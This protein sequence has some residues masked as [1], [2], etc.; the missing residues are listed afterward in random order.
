MTYEWIFMDEWRCE[1]ATLK[2]IVIKLTQKA[3][4]SKT[5]VNKICII[6]LNAML[7]WISLIG[8]LS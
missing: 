2:L 8:Q 6:I 3:Q 7:L 5:R 1:N 4:H